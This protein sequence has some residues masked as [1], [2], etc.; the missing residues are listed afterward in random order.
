MQALHKMAFFVWMCQSQYM[1]SARAL[2]QSNMFFKLMQ[3]HFEQATE[4]WFQDPAFNSL[5][6]FEGLPEYSLGIS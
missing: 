2:L 1:H 3:G 6:P 4:L 5:W